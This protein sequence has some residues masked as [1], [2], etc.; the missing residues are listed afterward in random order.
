MA[1]RLDFGL[2]FLPRGDD[3]AAQILTVVCAWCNRTVVRGPQNAAITHTICPSCVAWTME[4]RSDPDAFF[5]KIA[6]LGV[7]NPPSDYFGNIH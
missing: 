4:C 7:L 2:S 5:N 3:M 6:N 1:Y